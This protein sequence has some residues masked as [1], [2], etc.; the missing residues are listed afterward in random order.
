M[1]AL[2]AHRSSDQLTDDLV[3]GLAMDHGQ[4]PVF[5]FNLVAALS[6]VAYLETLDAPAGASK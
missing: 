3:A 5:D 2:L 6:L 4:M 1:S